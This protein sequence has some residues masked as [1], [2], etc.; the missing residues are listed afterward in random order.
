MISSANPT[1]RHARRANLISSHTM[2]TIMR[3]ANISMKEI[4]SLKIRQYLPGDEVQIIPLLKIPFPN[5]GS[6]APL[7][8][9]RWKHQNPSFQTSIIVV[10]EN[11]GRIIGCDHN[12]ILNIKVG[13]GVFTSS[14]GNDLA[15]HP[16]F[17]NKGVY[18][19]MRKLLWTLNEKNSVKFQFNWTHNPIMVKHVRK[20]GTRPRHTF[21][22]Q[23]KSLLWIGDVNL[24][25]RMNA[26]RTALILKFGLKVVRFVNRTIWNFRREHQR[27]ELLI[28]EVSSFD[29][30][31]NEFW[32]EVSTQYN[33]I[34]ERKQD[35]LNWR[36]SNLMIGEHTI[37]QAEENGKI[38]GYCIL[39]IDRQ[40]KNY[41]S[42]QIVDLLV[43]PD[44]P[45]IVDSLL[46][47][48][49]KYFVSKGVNV[50]NALIV[51]GHPYSKIFKKRGFVG[52][53]TKVHIGYIDN[54]IEKDVEKLATGPV[55]RV[56]ICYGDVSI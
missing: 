53:K 23:V 7:D 21:P 27:Q 3:G 54:G 43:L 22:F 42:G 16:D 31:I 32:R 2:V 38:V 45:Y 24:H 52:R 18:T 50:S 47:E 9:W 1:R 15:V 20:F 5:Y 4:E 14:V 48:V 29:A 46:A 55:S 6:T 26:R 11:R 39:S 25:Y 41:P 33:F 40:N 34:I 35:Y 8:Y 28:S 49:I 12:P 37:Q 30:R 13:N 10:A 19:S 36:Y 44:K 56:H 17:R 51:S